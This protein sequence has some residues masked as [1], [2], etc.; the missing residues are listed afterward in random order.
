MPDIG[1][2]Y[3]RYWDKPE[4][5]YDPT[6]PMRTALI[7]RHA[8]HLLGSG[9]R[10]LDAGCGRGEFCAFFK[11]GGAQ[12]EGIDI[13]ATGIEYARKQHPGVT[14]HAGVTESLLPGLRHAFDGVF[15]SE[16]VEHLFD[17]GTYLAAV[18]QLLKPGGTLV[19]TTP[20]HGLI[21][22]IL[23]DVANYHRHYDPLGQHI[24]F[25]DK[26]GLGE[27]LEAFGFAPK[28]WTGYGRPWPLWKSFFVVASK[29]REVDLAA[30]AQVL[31]A[32]GSA[33]A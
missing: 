28:V 18:N 32:R 16:V 30:A 7:R 12:A 15:S 17:V 20:Y 6:T 14:F 8:G 33:A 2:Y 3:E 29:A 5:Y 31:I 13:S 11:A 26:K 9:V 23:I 10:V 19:L 24:R 1:E 22:N 25:F 21:K 4:A 27:C